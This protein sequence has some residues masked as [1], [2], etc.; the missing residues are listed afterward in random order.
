MILGVV[1]DKPTIDSCHDTRVAY[2]NE[3]I[4]RIVRAAFPGAH[5]AEYFTWMKVYLPRLINEQSLMSSF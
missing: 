5:Y 1:Y 3:F 4:A 2:V